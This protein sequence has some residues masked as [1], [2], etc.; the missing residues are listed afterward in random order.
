MRVLGAWLCCMTDLHHLEH[1]VTAHRLSMRPGV[2]ATGGVVGAGAGDMAAAEAT[3]GALPMALINRPPMEWWMTGSSKSSRSTRHSSTSH[4]SLLH[5]NK[6]STHPWV[7]I[8]KQEEV[9]MAG[10]CTDGAVSHDQGCSPGSR[11][12]AVNPCVVVL[13]LLQ[14]PWAG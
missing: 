13:S 6:R 9:A 1:H 11:M 10:G 14:G 8:V 3:T 2:V 12:S 5:T 4:Q 7:R